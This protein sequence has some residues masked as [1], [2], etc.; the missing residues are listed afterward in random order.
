MK[1]KKVALMVVLS[2]F[3]LAGCAAGGSAA[4]DPTTAVSQEVT[5][6]AAETINPEILE[7]LASKTVDVKG[8]YIT[9]NIRRIGEE[10]TEKERDKDYKGYLK[11]IEV[12]EQ[13]GEMITVKAY[14]VDSD[15]FFTTAEKVDLEYNTKDGSIEIK[16]EK[17]KI[18]PTIF[19]DTSMFFG[20]IR[21]ANNYRVLDD[22]PDMTEENIKE[23]V[24]L[25]GVE[26]RGTQ[27]N[28]FS[29]NGC[30]KI[31][32]K[33][34]NVFLCDFYL[35]YKPYSEQDRFTREKMEKNQ[36]SIW[37]IQLVGVKKLE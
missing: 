36:S 23:I 32:D 19:F 4:A 24:L 1:L 27:M 35:Y 3:Y 22:L 9:I 20:T 8:Y 17:M 28:D 15:D 33:E 5:E 16:T 26:D 21:S 37:D 6:P 34:D 11:D 30:V 13:A 2:S 14:L 12:M 31:T 10:K 25:E 18:E 29:F 7:A